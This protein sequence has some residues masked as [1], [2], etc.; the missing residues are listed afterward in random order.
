MPP[1]AMA[2]AAPYEHLRVVGEGALQCPRPITPVDQLE[3]ERA[4]RIVI[5]EVSLAQR[6]EIGELTREAPDARP[7]LQGESIKR[8]E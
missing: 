1:Y 8:V 7:L 6:A 2:S 3:I 4:A 5:E